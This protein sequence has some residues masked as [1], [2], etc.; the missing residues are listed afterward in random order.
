MYFSLYMILIIFIQTSATKNSNKKFIYIKKSYKNTNISYKTYK[1]SSDTYQIPALKLGYGI[2]FLMIIKFLETFQK[3]ERY[4]YETKNL[5][6]AQK[7]YNLHNLYSLLLIRNVKNGNIV[8]EFTDPNY[9]D[10]SK[11]L[12]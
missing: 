11:K 12:I 10:N 3:L 4:C 5:K 2:Y 8:K 6:K 7:N 1:K 9:M